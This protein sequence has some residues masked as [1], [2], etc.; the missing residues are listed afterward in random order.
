M[1]INEYGKM[2]KKVLLLF[3]VLLIVIIAIV[4]IINNN[5][6]TKSSMENKINNSSFEYSERNETMNTNT[7]KDTEI[8]EEMDA[9]IKVIIDNKTYTAQLENN[10]TAEQFISM[11]PQELNMN[12]LNGNEKYIYLDNEFQ[13]NS[14]NPKHI[15]AGDIMLYGNNCLVIFYKSFNSNYSYTKIGHIENLSDLGNKNVSV[16]FEN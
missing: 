13:T 12:E 6:K 1:K 16:R 15:E 3:T 8:G 14:F 2:N 9:T 4:I 11:L 5:I 7:E 10:E